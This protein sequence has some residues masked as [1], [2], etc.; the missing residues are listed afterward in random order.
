MNN[1]KKA[2]GAI[3]LGAGTLV[4]MVVAGKLIKKGIKRREEQIEEIEFEESE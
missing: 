4:S 2:V 3:L 1:E